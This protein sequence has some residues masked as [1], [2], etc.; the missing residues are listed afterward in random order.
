MS[1]RKGNATQRRA[2]KYLE[3]QGYEVA[4]CELGGKFNKEKDLFGLFDLVALKE[5]EFPVFVQV[6]TNKPMKRELL[7]NF[8]Y[9]YQY[10]TCVCITWY[11][12]DGWRIQTY[13]QG[14]LSEKD[15]RKSKNK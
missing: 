13:F 7:V 15:L 8:S 9:K 11:D 5:G 14:N 10:L 4:K 3:E 2:I 6:K 1:K 12:R